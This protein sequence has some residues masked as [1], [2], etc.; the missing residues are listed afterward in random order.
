MALVESKYFVDGLEGACLYSHH[1]SSAWRQ[2][3]IVSRV[4]ELLIPSIARTS[5][6]TLAAIS[7]SAEPSSH[8]LFEVGSDVC[9]IAEVI[10][11]ILDKL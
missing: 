2:L 6:G 7:A 4:K 3:F 5:A 11:D 8:C 9:V 10:S 1:R